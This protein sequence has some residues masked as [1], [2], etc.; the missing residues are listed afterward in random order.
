MLTL[1]CLPGA[2]VLGFFV[3]PFAVVSFLPIYAGT[4]IFGFADFIFLL[5]EPFSLS[6]NSHLSLIFIAPIIIFAVLYVTVCISFSV[7]EKQ[8]RLGR[9]QLKKP[10]IDLKCYFKVGLKTILIVAL[11]AVIYF[12]IIISLNALQHLLFSNTLT[13]HYQEVYFSRA[14]AASIVTISI[15]SL[16]LFVLSLWLFAP[17]IFTIPLM[18]IYG[19][20]L[21]DAIRNSIS[22]Y[23]TKAFSISFGFGFIFFIAVLFSTVLAALDTFL[24]NFPAALRIIISIIIQ[25]F[26]LVYFVAYCMV[27]TFNIA[28]IQKRAKYGI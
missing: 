5:F 17:L 24:P 26:V 19:Y 11:I 23:A 13:H 28:G 20:S 3:R 8:F 2:V 25:G 6:T 22:Y 1:I 7:I 4:E 9:L 18:Q 16:V 12:A 10:F 14:S 15:I 27:T 21:A